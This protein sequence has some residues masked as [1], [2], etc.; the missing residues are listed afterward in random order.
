MSKRKLNKKG[1]SLIKVI[2]FF[3]IIILIP[4]YF[5]KNR[6]NNTNTDNSNTTVKENSKH[7]SFIDVVNTK[8]SNDELI[9][10]IFANGMDE[11]D[12]NAILNQKSNYIV[13][14]GTYEQI[15]YD[16]NYQLH[17]SKIEEIIYELTKSEIVNTEIIGQSADSRN[18]YSIEIGKGNKTLLIDA[19]IHAAETV[20][21]P[22]LIKFMVDVVN[23]YEKGDEDLKSKLNDYKIVILP[24]INPDGYEVYN[25]G[26]ESI[27]N[28]NLWIYKNKDKIDFENFKH[29]AN[30]VDINRN[31][32]TQNAGLY[33]KGKN[34]IKSVSLEKSYSKT[35]Y[36]GGESLG[37]EPETKALMYFML[38][39]Y[40][41]TFAYINMHSQGRVIYQ[42]KP[43]LNSKFNSKSNSLA[44]YI[45]SYN[46]YTI[47]GIESEEVAEG[48]DGSATDFM[49]EL[50]CGFKFSTK[51]GRLSI[52]EYNAETEQTYNYGVVTV[53]TI[54][55][56][57]RDPNYSKDE[58]YNRKYYKI[59][60]EL[61]KENSY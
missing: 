43:N 34:L 56:Y 30:G 38:K 7:T 5:I 14:S 27:N 18:I 33:Y 1:K 26:I 11:K 52:S 58:Y 13:S 41:N 54:T 2:I 48:N 22:L 28:R 21:T 10:K 35:A 50:A 61:L 44:K 15:K 12:F 42:G 16:F 45:S 49:A 36:F 47:Y 4:T 17:Y 37:S 25:F 53:E 46:N 6:T 23:N 59:F 8:E 24:C 32:P 31:M 57:S 55:T 20:N 51:T 39:H 19:N 3:I 9:E 40:K 60:T 29:N